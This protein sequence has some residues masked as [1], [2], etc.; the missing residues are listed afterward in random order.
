V[1]AKY[2][3][4]LLAVGFLA[5]ALMRRARGTPHSRAQVKTWLLVAVV[6]GTVSAW[7]FLRS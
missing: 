3:L 2:I 1:A 6:F 5:A 4:A 7:L